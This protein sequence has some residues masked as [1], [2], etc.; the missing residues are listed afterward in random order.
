MTERPQ[1]AEPRDQLHL[2]ARHPDACRSSSARGC[3]TARTPSPPT[4]RSRPAAPRACCSAR[5]AASA[6]GRS[7]SRTASCTTPTTTSAARS[8]RCRAPDPLPAGRHQL[9]FEF[10]P[11]GE[12]DIAQGK[13]APGRAQLY[14]D[15]Q[16]VAQD[17]VPGHHAH[18]LQ[19]GRPDLRRQ[20]RLADHP[21]LPGPVPASPAPCT[22][23]PS[24]CP[25]TSSPTPK[26]RCAWPWPGNRPPQPW[27]SSGRLA[28]IAWPLMLQQS[29]PARRSL[30]AGKQAVRHPG[31]RAV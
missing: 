2:P 8:T 17:R 21:R 28:W 9:R 13:G 5:A 26:A 31:Q 7:T 25:A 3:S 10:E 22:P 4:W 20:P 6:A 19:P 30:G 29:R 24:T 11:T 12:P 16:L 18:R 27:S 14:V 15:G 1:I 23:S